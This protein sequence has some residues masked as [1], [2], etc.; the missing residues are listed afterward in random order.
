MS[1]TELTNFLKS[2]DKGLLIL[3]RLNNKS[4]WNSKLKKI[5][6]IPHFYSNDFLDYQNEYFQKNCEELSFM[7]FKNDSFLFQLSLFKIKNKMKFFNNDGYLEIPND[8][9][10]LIF[11]KKIFGSK[12]NFFEFFNNTETEFLLPNKEYNIDLKKLDDCDSLNLSL[13]D[14]FENIMT[15]YRD[16][17]MNRLNKK[18][19]NLEYFTISKKKCDEDWKNFK[20]LHRNV[21]G[22]LTRSDTSWDIQYN[23]I[24]KGTSVFIYSKFNKKFIAGCLFDHSKDDMKYSVSASDPN[25]RK[26]NSNEK[27]ISL[28]IKY[29]KS[30]NIKNLHFGV[31]K[32]KETDIK[33]INIHDFKKNFCRKIN[34][35]YGIY[36]YT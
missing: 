22:R 12:K 19:D 30:I 13:E 23:N 21:A 34:N 31:L 32:K 29:A 9:L 35:N 24:Q 6:F 14:S 36:Q 5:S 3:P 20:S 2:M 8:L 17:T 26:F 4:L 16:S 15:N 28:A 11:E 33:K 7:A 10:E 27:I 25:F 1:S 18:F